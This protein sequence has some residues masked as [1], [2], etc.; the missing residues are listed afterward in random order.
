MEVFDHL[1]ISAIVEGKVF[2]IHGGLS[3]EIK[4]ID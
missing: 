3:P 4:T 1:P 2:C